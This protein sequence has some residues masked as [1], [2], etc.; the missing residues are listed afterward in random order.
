VLREAQHGEVALREF[1]QKEIS[2]F[3]M[4]QAYLRPAGE[5]T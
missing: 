3:A 1:L 2:Q 5:Q 4:A